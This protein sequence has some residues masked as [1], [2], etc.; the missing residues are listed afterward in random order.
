MMAGKQGEKTMNATNMAR[1]QLVCRMRG[2]LAV[3][4][5]TGLSAMTAPAAAADPLPV[6]AYPVNP[7][8]SKPPEDDGTRHRVPASDRSFT[9]TDLRNL[10]QVP[11]WHP[12]G[13]PPMPPIV[14]HG[15]KP[16][17]FAC[18][19]CHLPN[20]LGRPENSSLAGLPASYIVQQVLDFQSGAR[21]SSEPASLPINFMITVAKAVSDDD[22]RIAA[23]YFSKLKPQQWI[24]VVET[25]T[26]PRHE[27]G[28]W[29]LIA[30]KEG[31][32]EPI[33]NRIIEMPEDLER[34]EFRDPSSGF[35]AYV[36]TGSV[37]RGEALASGADGRVTACS[38]CHGAGLK[39]MG[40]VPALAGRS[41]SYI[42]RQL[43]DIK[44]GT[45]DG[46]WAAL[47]KPV[48][49]PMTMEDMVAVAAYTA[50]LAP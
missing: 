33:G 9:W 46:A 31:G 16:G 10:F 12:E 28:G 35:I 40:P 39:G 4:L 15:A 22:L 24:R 26:V 6:W 19:F 48:V 29:M 11:D 42:V 30:A 38:A 18:G 49:A 50:S 17:V 5:A 47:M 20:G 21:K 32:E 44:H 3:L 8:G 13:H 25:D 27:V 37:R 45:R 43:Y 36:P 7:P 23:E 1:K 14:E 2:L 41:P 34:T